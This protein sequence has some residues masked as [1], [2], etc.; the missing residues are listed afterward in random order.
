MQRILVYYD[1]ARLMQNLILLSFFFFHYY[2]GARLMQNL[3]LLLFLFSLHFALL[4]G[5]VFITISFKFIF[6]SF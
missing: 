4:L 2:D 3:I 5:A 6:I 1:S